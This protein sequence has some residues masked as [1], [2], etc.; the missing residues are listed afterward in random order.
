[1]HRIQFGKPEKIRR[2]INH[3]SLSFRCHSVFDLWEELWV[4]TFRAQIVQ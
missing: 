1:M 3:F 2:E 4:E